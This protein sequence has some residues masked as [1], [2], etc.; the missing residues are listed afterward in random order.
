MSAPCK[1]CGHTEGRLS[2]TR[3]G[4]LFREL[5][6]LLGQWKAMAFGDVAPPL[7]AIDQAGQKLALILADEQGLCVACADKVVLP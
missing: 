3:R 7:P 5:F 4:T 1:S 6:A 2:P